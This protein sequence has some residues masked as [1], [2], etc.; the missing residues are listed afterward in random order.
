MVSKRVDILRTVLKVRYYN[1]YN[2]TCF[3]IC[4]GLHDYGSMLLEVDV[5]IRMYG[6]H[7]VLLSVLRKTCVIHCMYDVACVCLCMVCRKMV[8]LCAWCKMYVT[9]SM[10]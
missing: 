3:I 8:L 9:V 5:T 1:Y 2:R 6:L 7:G 4:Y 10:M